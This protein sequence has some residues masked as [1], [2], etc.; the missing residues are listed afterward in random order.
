[1]K[2]K[3]SR[4]KKI[5]RWIVITLLIAAAT[6][7]FATANSISIA[8][9][10]GK[11]YGIRSIYDVSG[12]KYTLDSNNPEYFTEVNFQLIDQTAQIHAGV[13]VEKNSQVTWA[14]ECKQDGNR[15]SCRFDPGIHVLEADWL[16]V[17]E[18]K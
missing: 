15:F 1:M 16:H 10:S 7:G 4:Q 8:N 14:E 11:G 6:Y 17:V 2:S 13:S 12:I 18:L 9:L 3:E 5:S